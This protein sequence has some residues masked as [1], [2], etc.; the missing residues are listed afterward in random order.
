M[1]RSSNRA[2][3]CP[4][5]LAPVERRDWLWACPPG[6][7]RSG[8]PDG[9]APELDLERF[10][11]TRAD[12]E[13]QSQDCVRESGDPCRLTRIDLHPRGCDAL[14]SHPVAI[15]RARLHH[16]LFCN[17]AM[18]PDGTTDPDLPRLIAAHVMGLRLLG[19]GRFH[20]PMPADP[21]TMQRCFTPT[22]RAGA[23]MAGGDSGPCALR[24]PAR[25]R[26]AWDH[27]V[28]LHPW[29]GQWPEDGCARRQQMGLAQ[30][31]AAA[32]ALVIGLNAGRLC[33]KGNLADSG[34]L[35][36]L[37]QIFA[38]AA[39]RVHALGRLPRVWFCLL[40][41]ERLFLRLGGRTPRPAALLKLGR[42][43]LEQGLEGYVGRCTR[44]LH[45]DALRALVDLPW[46][47][48]RWSAVDGFPI[49]GPEA[50]AG[51]DGWCTA[52]VGGDG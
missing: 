37:I 33:S 48:K 28:Y 10:P 21:R 30:R 38:D 40:D 44:L 20:E 41:A 12:R 49:H 14:L 22:L 23:I 16:S 19:R 43:S 6:C 3:R 18:P 7:L 8:G 51:L 26:D 15:P 36:R 24:L 4:R 46:P 52:A 9:G 2:I 45:D 47:Q 32:D 34:A 13:E 29:A 39:Q 31:L 42:Q 17:L 50:V 35:A 11:G 1:D 27:F 25:D 5:C